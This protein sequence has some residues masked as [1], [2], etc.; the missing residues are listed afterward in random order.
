MGW[1]DYYKDYLS[2][3]GSGDDQCPLNHVHVPGFHPHQCLSISE[4]CIGVTKVEVRIL[5]KDQHLCHP[6]FKTT[7]MKIDNTTVICQDGYM[8]QIDLTL[9]QNFIYSCV[10]A[11]EGKCY[12]YYNSPRNR[13]CYRCYNFQSQIT[14][15]HLIYFNLQYSIYFNL[16]ILIQNIYIQGSSLTLSLN[17]FLI[18]NLSTFF[19]QFLQLV[20]HNFY[21]ITC[22]LILIC[23]YSLQI[24]FASLLFYFLT[25]NN[26][27]LKK[28]KLFFCQY[29]KLK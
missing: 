21:S 14:F 27:I 25:A 13:G 20:I 26:I 19:F 5:F 24:L 10:P 29:L 16:H 11:W 28:S 12:I 23:L 4:V 9:D 22:Q 15:Y 17:L 1:R 8:L 7:K 3:F 2:I 6:R 18:I